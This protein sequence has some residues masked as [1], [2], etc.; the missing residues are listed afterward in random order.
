[1][2]QP[3]YKDLIGGEYHLPW[4]R[5]HGL[6]DYYGMV[7]VLEDFP[8]VHQ[9]F[10]LVPS[11]MVQ[12][13]DYATGKAADPFLRVALKQAEHLTEDERR[14]LL[15]YFFQ[16]HVGNM[17]HRYPRYAQLHD[18][19]RRKGP[20][21]AQDF[22]DLQ[23]LSQVAWF[24]EVFLENDPAVRALVQ[25]GKHFDLDDQALMGR[26]QR[27]ILSQVA[28]VYGEFAQRGQIEISTTPFYH[29]IL[30][31]LCDTQVAAIA[32]P[33]VPLPTP[34]RY[35]EDAHEQLSRA[36][37]YMKQHFRVAPVGLWPSEGSVSDQA[38]EIAA[39]LGFRWAAT[40]NGV[41]TR[42]LNHMA[43]TE[44]TYRPYRWRRNGK[45]MSLLFRDHFLSDLIG[46]VYMRMGAEDAA[47]HFLD[48]IREN[49]SAFS[50]RGEDA[51]VPVILDGENAWEHY[52]GSGRPFLKRLYQM[53]SDDPSMEALTV[54]EAIE[55]VAPHELGTI[56]PGSWIN[57]N[58]DIWIGAHEDNQAWELVL[59][60]RRVYEDVLNGPEGD[61]LSADSKAL[62]YEELLIAEGSDWCWWYGPEHS[63]D[64]EAEFDHLFRS[65]LAN[66]Y[67]ALGRSAPE[68]LSRPITR[69]HQ[70]A[71][72]LHPTGPIEITVDGRVTSFFEWRCAGIYKPDR[73]SSSMHGQESPFREMYY[74]TNNTHLFLRMQFGDRPQ[75]LRVHMRFEEG[76]WDL[77][78]P[79]PKPAAPMEAAFSDVLEVAVPMAAIGG[80]AG[81]AVK[82]Q[83]SIWNGALP[84]E[85]LP[86]DGWLELAAAEATDW[87]S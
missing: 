62:A 25:K 28:P 42:T 29:P 4:T 72:H 2:H 3:F 59:A 1:M 84:L 55:R 76:E 43:G 8:Q 79:N 57:A 67:R 73:R 78:V 56:F 69:T 7:K 45:E 40:D 39:E 82:I 13:D 35:P 10:N 15:R 30:P 51:V 18:I 31:L 27:E 83:F 86:P 61:R 14:F 41:L 71:D 68:A 74:G 53:I 11:M 85:A 34:F 65:H 60:A 47:R 54:S 9:T 49:T 66:V 6:K 23:V 12:I 26:K 87:P 17:I 21:S 52:E 37:D 80:Q 36:R 77:A 33:G 5:M 63:S 48:R 20:L 58:F 19:A 70:L 24:D 46:F 32:H 38:L 16:A 81:N 75:E 64:N 22:R 44:E 50:R